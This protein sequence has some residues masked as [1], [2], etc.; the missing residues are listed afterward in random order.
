MK[1]LR[2]LAL[3]CSL[4]SLAIAANSAAEPKAASPAKQYTIIGV[5][6]D[7]PK[8]GLDLLQTAAKEIDKAM[9]AHGYTFT[10]K[11]ADQVEVVMVR[12]SRGK[13]EIDFNENIP[14][15]R[16]AWGGYVR[17]PEVFFPNNDWMRWKS[18]EKAES[19]RH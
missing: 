17:P 9:S 10:L 2:L 3:L 16:H 12:F 7:G 8:P 4:T 1:T 11:E 13:Y 5:V 15:S 18:M 6:V 14:G 19:G